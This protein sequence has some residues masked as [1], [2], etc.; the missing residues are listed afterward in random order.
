MTA[1]GDRPT[2]PASPV[3]AA[4]A[5]G[6]WATAVVGLVALPWHAHPLQSRGTA[7]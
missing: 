5:V 2:L 4:P 3:P 1:P 6:P 7:P